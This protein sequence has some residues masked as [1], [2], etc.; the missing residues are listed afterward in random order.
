MTGPPQL[1]ATDVVA[2]LHGSGHAFCSNFNLAVNKGNLGT[3]RASVDVNGRATDLVMM[4]DQQ[5]GCFVFPGGKLLP[6]PQVLLSL[7]LARGRNRMEFRVL[8]NASGDRIRVFADLFLWHAS[9]R[10]VVVDVDGTITKSDVRGLVA[11]QLQTTTVFLSNALTGSQDMATALNTDYTHDGVAEALTSI[12]EADYRILYLTARPITLADQTR[13]FLSSVGR[14]QNIGLPEGPLITQPHGTMK[15]LQTKHEAFKTD[16]LAQ[17][18]GLFDGTGNSLQGSPSKS[19]PIAFVAGFG[20]HETDVIAYSAAGIPRSH[21]FVLDKASNLRVLESGGEVQSYTGLLQHLPS[22]FPARASG[23]GQAANTAFGSPG[24][25]APGYSSVN[26]KHAR[27][28]VHDWGGHSSS[29]R[30]APPAPPNSWSGAVPTFW[31]DTD[32][33]AQ[34]LAA[35][36]QSIGEVSSAWSAREFMSNII[37]GV[38]DL[39]CTVQSNA[40]DGGRVPATDAIGSVLGHFS[41]PNQQRGQHVAHNLPPQVP[42][43]PSRS[44]H[45][46]PPGHVQTGAGHQHA[47]HQQGG[48][49]HQQGGAP[50]QFGAPQHCYNPPPHSVSQ[51][52]LPPGFAAA[53]F[54][55]DKAGETSRPRDAHSDS[56]W[57]LQSDGAHPGEVLYSL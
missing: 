45:V 9:D 32:R 6:E 51:G 41:P 47:A 31:Q 20:N 3:V 14:S 39:S 23:N 2:V 44:Q 57:R 42:P 35:K 27:S 16:V 36:R 53:T 46:P 40:Q 38:K 48:A 1:H 24:Q 34:P 15:A 28:A 56:D 4:H 30:Q 5:A 12:A 26:D 49:P 37:P 29:S 22:L 17:I 43:K 52:D 50:H 13:E 21:I 25:P 18:Q 54:P 11:S 10:V 19:L 33:S 7:P 8:D 55:P